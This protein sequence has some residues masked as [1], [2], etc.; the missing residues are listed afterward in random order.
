MSIIITKSYYYI[1]YIYI[2]YWSWLTHPWS[3][4][5]GWVYSYCCLARHRAPHQAPLKVSSELPRL[6]TGFY[7]ALLDLTELNLSFHGFFGSTLGTSGLVSHL[8]KRPT[9]KIQ[10]LGSH[11]KYWAE[12]LGISSNSPNLIFWSLLVNPIGSS[13]QH[14]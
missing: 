6:N 14:S 13:N 7:S 5:A 1:Y 12:I 11:K 4:F 10:I 9:E 2:Y 8:L 3:P